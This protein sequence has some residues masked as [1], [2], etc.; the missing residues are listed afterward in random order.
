M[1]LAI[2][3]LSFLVSC[4]ALWRAWKDHLT[5]KRKIAELT[6]KV[7]EAER[8]IAQR[9]ALANEVAHEIKNPLTAILCSAETLFHLLGPQL[10]E[11]HRKSLDYIRSYGDNLLKLVSDFLDISRASTGLI[12]A[13]PEPTTLPPIVE[14]IL[15]LLQANAMRKHISLRQFCTD[16]ALAAHVDPR[17][18]KQILFNLVHNAIKFTPDSGEVQVVIRSDFPNPFI[19]IAVRDNGPGLEQSAIP[20]LFDPYYHAANN[21]NPSNIGTGLG[22]ALCKEL[23]ELSGGSIWVESTVGVG[24]SFE[25]RLPAHFE[26]VH[27]TSSPASEAIKLGKP[28][29][30]QSFLVVEDEAGA[31]EAIAALIEAW[32]GVVDQVAEASAAVEALGKRNYDAVMIDETLPEANGYDLARKV[33]EILPGDNTTIIIASHNPCDRERLKKCGADRW[34]DKPLNGKALLNSLLHSGKFQVTH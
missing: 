17:H 5:A 28:L 7:N 25:F 1:I 19:T 29:E 14:S 24:T 12:E 15:G 21:P 8:I 23:V 30:G 27:K 26:P 34:I 33:R 22:L 31:R 6:H 2:I 20:H 4:A 9:G 32:G 3:Y 13:R 10:E 11:A 16:A 18:F